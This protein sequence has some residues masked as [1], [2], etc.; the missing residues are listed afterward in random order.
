MK[1]KVGDRV[2]ALG[3]KGTIVGVEP[4][5]PYPYRVQ[6]DN[7]NSSRLN[8]REQE[9]ELLQDTIPRQSDDAHKLIDQYVKLAEAAWQRYELTFDGEESE[10]RY[11]LG[12]ARM[13]DACLAA[14]REARL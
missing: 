7:A 6:D 8:Y 3:H 4:T 9:V 1:F 11:H 12:Q 2:L 5:F 13:A 10:W 14:L